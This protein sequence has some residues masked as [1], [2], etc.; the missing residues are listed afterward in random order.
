MNL[1][2]V[3]NTAE[4]VENDV[5][6]QT[7]TKFLAMEGDDVNLECS[8]NAVKLSSSLGMRLGFVFSTLQDPL[9]TIQE[10]NKTLSCDTDSSSVVFD[11]HWVITRK[12]GNCFLSI[13]GFG[14]ADNGQYGCHLFLTN[15]NSQYDSDWSNSVFLISSDELKP[16]SDFHNSILGLIVTTLFCILVVSM[17]VIVVAFGIILTGPIVQKCRRPGNILMS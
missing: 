4:L 5:S 9:S 16:S 7:S 2:V 1:T 15:S 11:P 3:N 17:V 6:E 10:Y 14:S 13:K 8:T 12:D